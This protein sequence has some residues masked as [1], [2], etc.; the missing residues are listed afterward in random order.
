MSTPK[1]MNFGRKMKATLVEMRMLVAGPQLEPIRIPLPSPKAL[2]QKSKPVV[3]LK[4][5]LPQRSIKELVAKIA[6]IEI[7]AAPASAKTKMTKREL[8]TPKTTSSKPSLQRSTRKK[9]KEPSLEPSIE[10]EEVE[11]SEEEEV[12]SSDEE[13]ESEEEAK[14][15]TPPL[16]KKK[17]KTQA[18]ERKKPTFAFKTPVFLKRPT[19]ILRKGKSSQKKPKRK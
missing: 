10:E 4:T 19:K 6:K 7:P 2:P 14:P 16:E 11:S 5:P 15:T 17:I 9:M 13:P 12:E 3:E 18:S 8:E 1:I